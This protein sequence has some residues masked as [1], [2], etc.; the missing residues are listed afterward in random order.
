MLEFDY[1][2]LTGRIREICVTQ[3]NFAKEIKISEK[4]LSNKLNN[5]KR[6]RQDQIL[7]ACDVLGI[8]SEDIKAYF[9]TVKVQKNEPNQSKTT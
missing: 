2:K 5:K 9:F 6:W 3:G 8:A 7:L 1:S 4:S